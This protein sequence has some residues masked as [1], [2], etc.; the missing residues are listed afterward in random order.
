MMMGTG[1]GQNEQ[2]EIK[3]FWAQ[4]FEHYL[5]DHLEVKEK[6]AFVIQMSFLVNLGFIISY[7]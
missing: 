5:I 2:I 6:E 4:V 1:Q 7:Y 3:K